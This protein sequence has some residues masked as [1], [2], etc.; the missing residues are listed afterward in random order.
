MKL[1]F[2]LVGAFNQEKALEGA[3]SVIVKSSGTFGNLRLKLY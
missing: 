2:V 3:F 1:V